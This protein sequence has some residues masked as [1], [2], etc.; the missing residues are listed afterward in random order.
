MKVS[1]AIILAACC[2]AFPSFAGPVEKNPVAT[3]QPLHEPWTMP[4]L[5]SGAHSNDAYTDGHILLNVPLWSTIGTD[6]TLGGSYLFLEPYTSIGEEGENA[7]SLGIGFR[8]LFNDQPISALTER[9]QA[10]FLEEGWYVGGS[11]FIDMLRTEHRNEFW[12]LGFGAEIG[13]RYL[14]LRGNYYLPLEGGRKSAGSQ[15]DRQTFTSSSTRRNTSLSGSDPFATGNLVLQDVTQTT[16]ATTTFRTTTLTRTTQFYERG[17]EGWD[18]EAGF[19]IPGLDEHM[20]VKIIGG[21]ASMENQPFGPQER[22]TGP[23]RG[24]RAGLEIRPVPAVVLTGLWHEN[25]AFTGSN[26]SAGIELQIPLDRTWKDAFKPRRRHLVERMAEPVHRQNAA[27]R[28][29]HSAETKTTSKTSVKRVTKVVSQ[30][31]QR[32]VLEDDIIFVNNGA[33]VGNGIQS[34]NDAAGDGTAEAPMATIQAGANIAMAN[35]NG[36]GRIWN[37]Y[38]QGTPAGYAEDV[39]ANAGSVNFIGSGRLIPGKGGKNFGAGPAPMLTGGFNANTIPFFGV[40][41]YRVVDGLSAAPA[42]VGI[43]INNVRRYLV[44]GNGLAD[45]NVGVNVFSDGIL[46]SGGTIRGNTITSGSMGIS[47]RGTDDAVQDVLIHHN[48]LVNNV[49]N[50][51]N[52]TLSSSVLNLTLQGN[53]FQGGGTAAFELNASDD[54]AVT[55]AST[56]NAF[57]NT[58][59]SAYEMFLTNASVVAGIISDDLL[60]NIGANGVDVHANE[61]ARVGLSVL[62][63]VMTNVTGDGI[64]VL[65][66]GDTVGLF[67]FNRNSFSQIT[68]QAIDIELTESADAVAFANLNTITA[69]NR[70][71]RAITRGVAG[72]DLASDFNAIVNSANTGMELRTFDTSGITGALTGN[73]IQTPVNQAFVTVAGDTSLLTAIISHNTVVHPGN[74]GIHGIA[75]NLGA[76]DL[77]FS[78]NTVIDAPEEHV[79]VYSEDSGALL[80]Q[81]HRN[82]LLTTG[83]VDG[84]GGVR[85]QALGSSSHTM[86][87]SQNTIADLGPPGTGSWG[88]SVSGRDT[89]SMVVYINQNVISNVQTNS[90][91]V[92]TEESASA[93]GVITGNVVTGIQAMGVGIFVAGHGTMDFQVTFNTVQNV[94]GRGIGALA[95]DGGDLHLDVAFNVVNNTGLDGIEFRANPGSVGLSVLNFDGNTV[96]NTGGDAGVIFLEEPGSTM[97]IYGTPGTGNNIIDGSATWR[98]LDQFGTTEGIFHIGPPVNADRL[99][100]TS[101]P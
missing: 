74:I 28:I 56:S 81:I 17:M 45:V 66:E 51:I 23:I 32:I 92:G 78:D 10:A 49:G 97:T 38:S 84:G 88:I 15:V 20:D 58:G 44:D 5:G 65:A 82:N 43:N 2:L 12:Q 29:A 79:L 57:Q 39:Q 80:S 42:G 4:L 11:L 48:A 70:G 71:V 91:N 26:W 50:D 8:H 62:R 35:S 19:L 89:S 85:M 61:D 22:G 27:I 7:S 73:Y 67:G 14:E 6:G 86:V 95:M 13:T 83:A 59:T 46:N 18:I 77:N 9:G 87:L 76:L 37:V 34:G 40:T 96:L 69:A 31:S 25:E 21:Y 54:A 100:N 53:R 16:T 24:W 63:N 52:V 60:A 99:D 72:L 94:A 93:E 1:H 55:F 36:T 98:V 64:S 41:A 3:T 47:V 30:S 68:G 33:P 90:L 75:R 101:V